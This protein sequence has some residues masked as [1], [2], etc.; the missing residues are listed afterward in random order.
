MLVERGLGYLAAARQGLTEDEVLEVLTEDDAVWASLMNSA[1][2]AG[3]PDLNP[4]GVAS[5]VTKDIPEMIGEERQLYP[6]VI[7][8]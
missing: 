1:L 3:D 2:G 4:D 5:V 6:N 7:F 8:I